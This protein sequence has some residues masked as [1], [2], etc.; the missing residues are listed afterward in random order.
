MERGMNSDRVW[1]G[2]PPS[3]VRSGHPGGS[4]GNILAGW[5]ICTALGVL[6]FGGVEPRALMVVEAA[7]LSLFAAHLW[8]HQPRRRP[9]QSPWQGPALLLGLLLMQFLFL[10]SVNQYFG[11]QLLR[12]VLYLCAFVL[13]A[14]LGRDPRIRRRAIVVLVW[15]GFLE[16][17]YG[18][19]MFLARSEKILYIDKYAYLDRATGTYVNP[20]HFAGLLGMLMPL[21]LAMGF[22]NLQDLR[23]AR[24]PM[25]VNEHFWAAVFF[26]TVALVQLTGIM[27]SQSRLGL[28]SVVCGLLAVGILTLAASWRRRPAAIAL[29]I[30]LVL[31]LGVG[32]WIGAEPIATRYEVLESAYAG[33]KAIWVDTLGIIQDSPVLGAGL[34]SFQVEYTK[35]QSVYLEYL[36]DHAHNDYL[37]F[38]AE[39]GLPGVVLL[40]GMIFLVLVR[41]IM[42]V[43]RSRRGRDWLLV[44]GMCGSVI[45]LLVHSFG[46]FNLQIPANAMVFAA[47]LGLLYASVEPFARKS[48]SADRLES[49]SQPSGG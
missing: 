5:A 4:E 43:R 10:P 47:V 16:A 35:H 7:F 34:G 48:A 23:R 15:I 24:D 46:D 8:L 27:L 40:F 38:A 37:Q 18:A 20:N 9:V 11:G 41:G 17:L 21:S 44:A 1:S 2:S 28:I 33:R 22:K 6:F 12:V 30:F 29:G 32:L 42:S 49:G 14:D 39:L 3:R 13:L 26:M 36:V 31:S 25:K 45:A 19:G